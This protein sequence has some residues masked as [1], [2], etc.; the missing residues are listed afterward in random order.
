MPK[1][2]ISPSPEKDIMEGS[3]KDKKPA[4]TKASKD[5]RNSTNSRI[6]KAILELSSR[7]KEHEN[8]KNEIQ[9]RIDEIGE[10]LRL[11]VVR[12]ETKLREL[13]ETHFTDEDTR[14]QTALN[15]LKDLSK[16]ATPAEVSETLKEAEGALGVEQRYVLTQPKHGNVIEWVYETLFKEF[17]I[18]VGQ[19]LTEHTISGRTPRI[20]EVTGA[21]GPNEVEL[22]IDFLRSEESKVLENKNFWKGIDYTVEMWNGEKDESYEIRNVQELGLAHKAYLEWRFKPGEDI[23]IRSKASWNGVDGNRRHSGWGDW[24]TFTAPPDLRNGGIK[25]TGLVWSRKHRGEMYTLVD[26][27]SKSVLY[28]GPN[29]YF[30]VTD[31]KHK[32]KVIVK[33]T[34]GDEK[35]EDVL[36][37][38][39][40][41]ETPEYILNDLRLFFNDLSICKK[42]LT[43]IASLTHCKII[44]T[45]IIIIINVYINS[46]IIIIN[47][48]NTYKM[49]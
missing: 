49:K 24:V 30:L 21:A 14:L 12:F 13:L 47:N 20:T 17:Y 1:E 10:I 33:G 43:K 4:P 26:K 42:T 2:R 38:K 15:S 48:N 11:S 23:K 5:A 36:K 39:P 3:D 45:L 27:L 25:A 46:I 41:E 9:Q 34:R 32:K 19:S 40:L 6:T 37:V 31:N 8:N 44:I 18:R 28:N 29:P 7:I 22:T 35:W 16:S